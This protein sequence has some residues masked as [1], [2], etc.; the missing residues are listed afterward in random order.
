LGAGAKANPFFDG[1]LAA[2]LEQKAVDS[3]K[4]I[5][6]TFAS[7]DIAAV[8]GEFWVAEINSG[9]LIENFDCQ[10]PC[11]GYDFYEKAKNVFREAL[12][13]VFVDKK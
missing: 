7:V 8:D 5:G 3:S 12:I 10:P 4:A 2:V 11:N 9:V 6:I 13:T 1:S